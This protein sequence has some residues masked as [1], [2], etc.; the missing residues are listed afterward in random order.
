[1]SEIKIKLLD[2]QKIRW[3][4][5]TDF[6]ELYKYM[7]LWLEDNGYADQRNLEKQYIE[8]IK[9]DGKKQI[10]ISWETKKSKSEF[11]DYHID[12][13]ILVLRMGDVEIQEEGAKRKMQ[14]GDFEIRITSY[15]KSTDKWNQLRGLQKLYREMF[16]RKR[17]DVYLEEIYKKST[18]FQSYIKTFLGM[19]D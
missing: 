12:V 14:K 7:K 17:I 6:P 19:R 5:V 2:S 9:P 3:V 10:E 16:I 1:M 18:S 8:K 11:F 4:G 15:L 13:T